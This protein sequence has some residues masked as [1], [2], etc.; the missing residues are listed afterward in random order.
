[1]S[2]SIGGRIRSDD[3]PREETVMILVVGATGTNGREVIE[4][5]AASG[6]SVRAMVRNPA[7][8]DDLRKP[9]VEVVAGDLEDPSSL[10]SALKGVE[11]AFF[12]AAVHPRYSDWF[13]NFLAAARGSGSTPYVVK[14]SGMGAGGGS[15]S[16]LMRQHGE[17]DEALAGSGLP[18]RS[19]GPTRSIRTCSGRPAPSRI[20]A[21]STCRSVMPG[22]AWWTCGISPPWPS[23]S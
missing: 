2:A 5:L 16:E 3:Q 7:K 18:L 15:P 17:T 10:A 4:Q 1:M 21:P 11:R 12:L 22:R 9:G 23:R 13:R 8:A 14:F 6:Q 20:M 19:C